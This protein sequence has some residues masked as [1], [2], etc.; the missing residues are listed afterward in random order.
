MGGYAGNTNEFADALV[1]M[2]RQNLGVTVEVRY[3]DPEDYTNASFKEHGQIAVG[4]WCADYPD[5]ENFLD[6]LFFTGSK[7]NYAGYSNLGVDVLLQ[8]ARIEQDGAKRIGIY[9]QVEKELLADYA[10]IPLVHDQT[11]VLVKPEVKGF[12]ISKMGTR[13]LTDVSL[14]RK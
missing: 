5:P 7:F 13:I 3:L 1:N 11:Y 6:L 4:S 12:S 9:Q 14:N 8:Q 2:W 10:A